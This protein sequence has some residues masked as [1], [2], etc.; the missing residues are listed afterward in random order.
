LC[1]YKI[2]NS[3]R[4]PFLEYLLTDVN[5]TLDFHT[6]PLLEK[7]EQNGGLRGLCP[8][9]EQN[10]DLS[11]R[12]ILTIASNF[13]FKVTG[14]AFEN[15]LLKKMEENGGLRGLCP[16]SE[17]NFVPFFQKGGEQHI[18]SYTGYKRYNGCI[19]LFID[20][21]SCDLKKCHGVQF[22]LIDEIVNVKHVYNKPI[23][24]MVTN[25]I[26]DNMSLFT[27][28]DVKNNA[29]EIPSAVYVGCDQANLNFTYTFGNRKSHEN[30]ML[31]PHYYFTS[32]ENASKEYGAVR[33]SIFTGHTL[34]KLNFTNDEIDESLLKQQK[35]D[36]KYELMTQRVTDHDAK[37]ASNY[38]SVYLGHIELDDGQML[39]NTPIIVVK[40]HDQQIALDYQINHDASDFLNVSF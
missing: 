40:S 27:I 31:G 10:G 30:T 35:L 23:A 25:F 20:I 21:S 17:Q 13:L 11:T 1:C 24:P 12:N 26:R 7:V 4:Q 3:G 6:V 33:F 18:L 28:L 8:R 38:D 9:V 2:N 39:L 14:V 16:R 36:N 32:F 15:P 19:Y 22:C 5:K 29:F 37:W 34:V